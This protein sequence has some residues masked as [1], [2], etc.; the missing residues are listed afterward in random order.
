MASSTDRPGVARVHRGLAFVALAW[1]I[2][3]FFLAGYAA[4]GGSSFDAHSAS[5]SFMGLLTLVI[6]I[7]AAVGHRSALQASAVLF[8]LMI[9]Q[10]IL[11]GVGTDAPALGAL[12]PVVG[13]LILGVAS[14]AAAGR[15]VG[16]HG[17]RSTA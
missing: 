6:L 5:G 9:V 4:F 8:V 1:G 11:G 17:H 14:L 16:P 15:P 3:Q 12:H 10:S 13:L 7:L 2:L